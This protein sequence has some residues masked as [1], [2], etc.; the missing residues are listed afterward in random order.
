MGTTRKLGLKHILQQS[1]TLTFCLTTHILSAVA[2]GTYSEPSMTSFIQTSLMGL[3]CFSIINL[4][5]PHGTTNLTA[6]LPALGDLHCRSRGDAP[7]NE[8]LRPRHRGGV[9]H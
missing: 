6:P 9:R 8:V 1:H 7:G 2:H 5:Y 3:P 4:F